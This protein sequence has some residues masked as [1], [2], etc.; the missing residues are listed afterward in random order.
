LAEQTEGGGS[1]AWGLVGRYVR[2]REQ[3]RS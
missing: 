2:C 1:R 3:C